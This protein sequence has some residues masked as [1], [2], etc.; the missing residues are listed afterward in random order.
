MHIEGNVAHDRV[1]VLLQR[2]QDWKE[3]AFHR[4]LYDMFPVGCRSTVE[5][6]LFL[7]FPKSWK[8]DALWPV[9]S[10]ENKAGLCAL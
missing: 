8:K 7:R 1:E 5:S 4:P 6:D 10:L 9:F 3:T 2:D